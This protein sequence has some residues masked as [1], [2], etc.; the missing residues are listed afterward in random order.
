MPNM[1]VAVSSRSTHAAPDSALDVELIAICAVGKALSAL[2]DP[3]AR[4]RVLEWANTR[5]GPISAR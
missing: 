5:F 2:E 3:Q 4:L 1:I